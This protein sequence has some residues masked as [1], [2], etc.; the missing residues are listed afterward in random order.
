MIAALK[1]KRNVFHLERSSINFIHTKIRAVK[2][3]SKSG[4]VPQEEH[5]DE[6]TVDEMPVDKTRHETEEEL[7]MIKQYK[8]V[9]NYK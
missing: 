9:H 5:V 8:Y 6:T 3:L 1:K 7:L 4:F 2:V